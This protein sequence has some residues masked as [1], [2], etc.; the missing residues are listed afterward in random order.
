MFPDPLDDH[1]K[2]VLCQFI[3]ISLSED[4]ECNHEDK[5]AGSKETEGDKFNEL[6][7]S[8]E[9]TVMIKSLSAKDAATISN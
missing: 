6:A 1:F 5:S 9:K 3:L 4:K 8:A 7:A 2:V